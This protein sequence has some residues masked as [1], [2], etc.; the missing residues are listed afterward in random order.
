MCASTIEKS[1]DLG[2]LSYLAKTELEWVTIG[3]DTP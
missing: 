3:H 2:L 1:V